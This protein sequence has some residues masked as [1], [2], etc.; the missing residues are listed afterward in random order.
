MSQREDVNPRGG[1]TNRAFVSA[2]HSLKQ[3]GCSLLVVGAVTDSVSTTVC[4]SMLGDSDF[5]TRRRLF[6]ATDREAATACDLLPTAVQ[7]PDPGRVK[8]VSFSGAIRHATTQSQ[9][10]QP[11]VPVERVP[12][13]ELSDLGIVISEAIA[14]FEAQAG[15]LAPAEV[16]VCLDSLT[17]LVEYDH[18]RL[19]Q[20]LDLLNGRIRDVGG[21]A[22]MHLQVDRDSEIVHLLEPLFDAVVE[23][24][25]HNGEPEQRWY[26][27]DSDL[28]SGWISRV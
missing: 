20:F 28:R 24:R 16:R 25:E 18:E 21:M 22:H 5:S 17:P 26:L 4:Q 6:V 14:D 9:S 12:R 19:F 11:Q 13:S 27:Q 7:N 2:L 1:E 10:P 3:K 23:L 15:T 8:V